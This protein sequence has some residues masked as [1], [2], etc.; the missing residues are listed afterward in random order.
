ME[1]VSRYFLNSCACDLESGPCV[2]PAWKSQ[3]APRK[4]HTFPWRSQILPSS[5]PMRMGPPFRKRKI[6]KAW[7]LSTQ[8]C[9]KR[10]SCMNV[11]L[12][13]QKSCSD[14]AMIFWKEASI[15]RL[16]LNPSKVGRLQMIWN[17]SIISR[18][19]RVIQ[20]AL[21]PFG[22][23]VQLLW[24]GTQPTWIGIDTTK[25]ETFH[26]KTYLQKLQPHSSHVHL[27]S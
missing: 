26:G 27:A 12:V 10:S 9:G 7:T 23:H 4:S 21:A 16:N 5:Q 20:N 25:V 6:H 19:V 17:L 18:R 3:T 11:H 15:S 8:S 1:I 2:A 22:E 24:T 13:A 14:A